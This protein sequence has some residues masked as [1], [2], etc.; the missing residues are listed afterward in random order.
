VLRMRDQ[1]ANVC[2][3]CASKI[4]HDVCV[5]VRD[6]RAAH[7]ESL[8]PALIDEAASPDSFDFLEN[9]PGAG[10]NLKPGMP[11]P[12]PTEILLN[13]A[14]HDRGVAALE[15]K[16]GTQRH[17][18][19]MMEKG[20]VVRELHGGLVNDSATTILHQQIGRFKYVGY[21]TR[22][23]AFGSGRKE[24]EILP[25]GTTDRR[26]N[27]R[28]VLNA[29]PSRFHHDW[30]QLSEHS[31]RLCP[32]F[33]VIGKAPTLR[34]VPDDQSAKALI[35]NEDVCAKSEHKPGDA[36]L[37]SDSYSRSEIVRGRSI[38]QGIGRTADPERGVRGKYFAL[39]QT[40]RFETRE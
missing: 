5:N 21:E 8:E 37:A 22:P 10:M 23:I 4:H 11:S 12:A 13:H 36:M 32:Q 16:R 40:S 27:S 35:T 20:I 15:R 24:V 38:V 2:R 25:Y 34:P 33:S 1:R 26:W 6:L 28:V 39:H 3:S 19:V 14:L 7:P 17:V 18:T 31:S 9:R 30:N 29:A